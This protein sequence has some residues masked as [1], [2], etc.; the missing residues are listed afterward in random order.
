MVFLFSLILAFSLAWFGAKPI[1]KHARLFY[2]G[3]A[4]LSILVI[5][6]TYS[7]ISFRFPTWIQNYIWPIF[8]NCTFATALFVIVRMTGAL[9][10]GSA[11]IKRLMPIR[12]ELSIIA[13]IL[14]LGH[15]IGYGKTYFVM[16]FT[17]PE[18]LSGNLCLAAIC[19]LIMILI[20]I[21][22]M[23]TSFPKVRR[24]MKAK[25]WKKAS[26]FRIRLLRLDLPACYAA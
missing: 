8:A 23:I 9:P 7:G 11:A 22:L 26:A 21:P 24:K 25:N 13:S 4:V 15:N 3:A 16:L 12:A 18:R 6:I 19:S 14:T 10:N 20:M 17:A 2:I 1:K 5:V